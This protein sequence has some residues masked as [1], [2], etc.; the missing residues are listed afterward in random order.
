MPQ[1]KKYIYQIKVTLQ[2]IR[3]PIWRRILIDS[4]E[5]LDNLHMIIQIAMGW[6]NVHLHQFFDGEK[7]YGIPDPEFDDPFYKIHH[8]GVVKINSIL[9]EEKDKLYYM[10][11]FGDGWEHVIE[12]EKILPFDKKQ[13]L[14]ECIKGR[15][16]CP[17]EDCGGIP[18]YE[19]LLEIIED[20]SHPEY[21]D[22]IS[23]LSGLRQSDDDETVV[24]DPA[25]FNKDE[26]N[27]I[28]HNP[29]NWE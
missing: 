27:A 14:P 1:Q 18:G 23:W 6:Q 2:D 10:Y 15:R 25:K 19:D 28:Y 11:D 12:L 7:Y 9:K 24:F 13:A 22:A 29:N 8:E 21:Q 5:Y 26:I 4:Y 20:P 17:P 16:A 3:P